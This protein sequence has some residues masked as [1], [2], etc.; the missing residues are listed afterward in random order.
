MRQ[1]FCVCLF[2][3]LLFSFSAGNA[4]GLISYTY[5]Y[6][7]NLGNPAGVNSEGD[8]VVDGTWAVAMPG[9]Q[10]QNTWS[11]GHA[12]PI[13]F[14]FFGT[15]VDS[16]WVSA[17]GMLTFSSPSGSP[18][19]S[20]TNLPSG[21]LPNLSIACF[22]ESFTSNIPTGSNDMVV[23]KSFGTSPNRQFWI[24]WASFE[25]ASSSFVFASIVLEESTDKV[26]IVDMY[27]SPTATTLDPVVGLQK[28]SSF[29][30][31][32]SSAEA[33]FAGLGSSEVDN[34]Y[35]TFEPYEIPPHDLV[36]TDLL[37]PASGGCGLGMTPVSIRVANLGQLPATNMKARFRVDE[38]AWITETIPGT[39]QAGDS[40][41]F[42]FQQMADLS[43]PGDRELTIALFLNGDGNIHN[44]TLNAV[45]P[46]YLLID[47][48]PYQE[49]FESGAA[50]WRSGGTNS[51]W[52]LAEP[53]GNFIQGAAS[54]VNAWVTGAISQHNS[55]EH[56]WVESPCFDL[57]NAPQDCWIGM[58]VYWES[59]FGWD[60]AVFQVSSDGGANWETLGTSHESDWYNSQ[61]INSSPGGSIFGW[62]GHGTSNTHAKVWKPVTHALPQ[63][64]IGQP[65]VRFRMVFASAGGQNFDGF[66][67][68]QFVI[69]EP[70]SDPDLE[71]GFVCN[72]TLIDAF[73]GTNQVLWSTGDTTSQITLTHTGEADI[74]DSM[75]TVRVENELGLFKRDTII[76][77]ISV[78]TVA[79]LDT[80]F[81]IDCH[82]GSTGAILL[83][84]KGG[85]APFTYEWSNGM[86]TQNLDQVKAGTYSG[87]GADATGCPF[88]LPEV[89]LT[90][91]PP[92]TVETTA[93]P[94]TCYGDA[95][96][97]VFVFASGGAGDFSY[98]WNHGPTDS[99]LDNVSSG[100]Y[101]VTVLDGLGCLK[102][103]E[104]E[105]PQP[106]S[107][108]MD[109]IAYDPNP[110]PG[111]MEGRLKMAVSGG[112][113]PYTYAW[114]HGVISRTAA[115]LPVGS[116]YLTVVDSQGCARTSQWME[117]GYI[118]DEPVADFSI[119]QTG[120]MV[121]L[122]DASQHGDSLWWSL[123]D[124]NMSTDSMPIH[125]YAQG[126]IYEITQ[127][128][129]NG[130]GTDSASQNISIQSVGILPTLDQGLAR[131]VPNPSEGRFILFLED[132]Q[133]LGGKISLMGTDG[134]TLWQGY[135]P[136][137]LPDD[138]WPI[139][140]RGRINQ[141]IYLLQV[142]TSVGNWISR[143]IIR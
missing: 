54:G 57:S 33:V 98:Q 134:R 132:R 94:V 136:D 118:Q 49:D 100:A 74:L 130:C 69:G 26:Y 121:E 36:P 72:E 41:L 34:S 87:T 79:T 138:K 35:F 47:Q 110:C 1:I 67:F 115:G 6:S 111:D 43:T 8:D 38:G 89:I 59:E 70:P 65:E 55:F 63:S 108:T 104:I 131:V 83:G 56:S 32:A 78:P 90:Q 141:G 81:H 123:G 126:G 21:G 142:E 125:T 105:V 20:A 119:N 127:Y 97:S 68:D 135:I 19:N 14:D 86:T 116:Y 129:Q 95:D 62:S 52:E 24:K 107:L 122:M 23:T 27:T 15:E 7:E 37:S 112:V 113:E 40:V 80:A 106:D 71:S 18:S 117:V 9:L 109:L 39:I 88:V 133:L 102:I 139:D 75:I 44:D 11:A 66:A 10:F 99:Q 76:F 73:S 128:V 17:N 96:G 120:E 48:F 50:G 84:I 143:V 29:A 77:S 101:S 85:K 92:I 60:G 103:R 13:D 25:W 114:S 5:S 46:H 137:Y 16:F 124:G 30:V 61:Q 3:W 28:N 4:Q 12:L 58:Q 22:W 2:T 91:N 82:G 51:S 140:L 31:G 42:T 53:N 64:V 45:I 93:T